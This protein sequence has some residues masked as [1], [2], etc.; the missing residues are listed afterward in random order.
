MPTEAD[1]LIFSISNTKDIEGVTTRLLHIDVKGYSKHQFDF[2]L[3]DDNVKIL[4]LDLDTI[5]L[6]Q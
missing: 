1:E 2:L 5:E 4:K 6:A 3:T